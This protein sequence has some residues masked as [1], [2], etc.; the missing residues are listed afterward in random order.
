MQHHGSDRWTASFTPEAC[1][2]WEFAV[3]AWVDRFAS[4]RRLDAP[5]SWR[6]GSLPCNRHVW[7][8]RARRRLKDDALLYQRVIARR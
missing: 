6:P 5:S 1:G 7:V 8:V 2:G 4:W 3:G